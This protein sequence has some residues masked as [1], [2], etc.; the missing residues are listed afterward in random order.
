[1]RYHITTLLCRLGFHKPR[2]WQE[3]HRKHH[4]GWVYKIVRGEGAKC[5]RCGK[6]LWRKDY[7]KRGRDIWV[8]REKKLSLKIWED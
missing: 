3:L 7:D 6:Q 2:Y 8:R 4:N 5:A 1:M